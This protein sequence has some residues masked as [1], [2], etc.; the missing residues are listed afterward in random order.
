MSLSLTF[1]Q[2][3]IIML[4][5]LAIAFP[6]IAWGAIVLKRRHDRKRD[7]ITGGF[8]AGVSERT[9]NDSR[10]EVSAANTFDGSG[11]N[12]PARTRDAFMPYGYGY[13]RSASRN[14]SQTA[15]NEANRHPLS[16]GQ[17]PMGDMEKDIGTSPPKGKKK[18]LVREK[19]NEKSDSGGSWM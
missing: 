15:V 19:S 14:A 3:W 6:L 13:S 11:R 4:I 8:N 7:Q 10:L 16:R 9:V 5:I 18:I 17:T 12:S 1:S 2:Q